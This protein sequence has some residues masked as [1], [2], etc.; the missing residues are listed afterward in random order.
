MDAYELIFIKIIET[1]LKKHHGHTTK[2]TCNPDSVG[3]ELKFENE[4]F[5]IKI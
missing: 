3:V 1:L 4:N 2:K 5:L